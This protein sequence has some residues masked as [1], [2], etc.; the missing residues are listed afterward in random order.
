MA[1]E[2]VDLVVLGEALGGTPWGA[3]TRALHRR[4]TATVQAEYQQGVNEWRAAPAPGCV[5]VAADA[6]ALD[7]WYRQHREDTDLATENPV[8]DLL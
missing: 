5:M 3:I 2:V 7:A 6:Q 4:E 8:S 1:H